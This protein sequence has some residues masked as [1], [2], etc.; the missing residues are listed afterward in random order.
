VAQG[1]REEIL[2]AG[3]AADE[4]RETLLALR[5]AL[6]AESER[7]VESTELSVRSTQE[8]TTTLGRERS[9]MG[10]LSHSLDAQAIRV[11]DMIT[12]QARMVAE[13]S[14]VAETQLR[15]AEA[16]LSTR[17]ADIVAAAGE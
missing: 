4:A 15:E 5:E 9:E 11:A 13:A 1:V 12:Q 16:A 17:A 14:E 10:A 6:A 7:L 2:R 8:L 3:A